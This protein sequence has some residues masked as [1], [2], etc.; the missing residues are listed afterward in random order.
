VA[1]VLISSSSYQA[2]AIKI[3]LDETTEL[4]KK[5]YMEVE[6]ESEVEESNQLE[7]ETNSVSNIYGIPSKEEKA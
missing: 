7:E 4:E 1:E 2:N 3:K 5:S 6:L